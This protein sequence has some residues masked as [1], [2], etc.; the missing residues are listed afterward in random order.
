M[1]SSEEMLYVKGARIWIPNEENVWEGAVLEQDYTKDCKE[2][3]AYKDAGHQQI[4]IKIKSANDLPPLR[5]PTILIGQQ[6]LTAL[7]YLHEPAVLHNL[8][9]RFRERQS[10]Y[11]YCGIILVA[12]NPYAKLPLYGPDI[13]RAYRGHSIG[14]LE[15]HIFALAE[16]AYTKLEREKCDLSIIVSGESGAGKTVSAKYA[17]RY[18]A[19][20]GGSESETQVE[21]KVLESSPI[22]E[23]FGNAKTTRNDNSSRFGKFT[24]L[25]FK[26]NMGVMNLTGATMQTYL[27][28]KSRV[29]YQS[30][31][32]RNYH[33]FYQLCSAREQH[34]E[35]M[36]DHQ[37]KFNFLNKGK[38]PDIERV[39]DVDQFKETVQAM[40][41][42]GFGPT[43]IS[44]IL[45]ILAGIL[46]LGNIQ[47]V[48][49][50]KKDTN[51]IDSDAC[52]I[53]P[54]DLPL[55]V[56]G[57]ML[58]IKADDLRKWLITRQIES[59]HENVLIPNNIAAAESAKDALAKHIYSKLF[60]YIV[61]VINKS[62]NS[63]RKQSCFIGV[64]DIYGFETF[65]TNS[66]EQFCINYANEKL[67][68]QFN[69]HVFKL[70]QEEYLK[71]G[72]VWTMI[73]FYDNQPCIDM[74]ES[75]LGVL[76]LLDEE[77]RMPK[78]SDESW[79]GKL[80]E[81]C[82]K[83][84]HF[85]K[86]RFGTTSF[87]VKHFSDTVQYDVHGF[88]EKNRD[89]VSKELVNVV[90]QSEMTLCK[91]L[92]ELEETDTL[93]EAKTT[94]GGRVVISAS[95]QTL[96][97]D[98][99]K[100][101]TPSKQ[102]KRSVGSQFRDSLSLLIST[103]HSTTPHYVRCIKPNDDK[104][105]FKWEASKI[106]Q[107]LR[108]CGVLE[109]VRISAAG[110]PSRWSYHDFYTRYQLLCHR[111]FLNKSD[112]KSS[113]QN[114]VTKW[115]HDE[116]KYRFGNTQIFFRAGQVAY[117][118][119]VRMNL[120]KKY[121]ITVQSV[122]RKFVYRMRYQRIQRVVLGLQTFARGYIA[123][124][125]ARAIREARAAL[126]ISKYARGY[127]CRRR[128]LKLRF[129][130]C[131]I[132][133]YARGMLARHR[134]KLAMDNHR[135]TQI[136]R[137]C[138][139]YLARQAYKKKLRS[140][141]VCQSAI[142]RFLARRLFRKLKAE[143]KT[144]SHIQNLYK[145]LENKIISLQQKIDELNKENT[146]L[147][148]K[149]TAIPVL[150][151]QLEQKKNI[152]NQLKQLKLLLE[153]KENAL[154]AVDKQLEAE[155]D[156]KMQLL[157][158]KDHEREEWSKQK[159]T[160]RI[161][162]EELRKQV[163]EMIELAKK[164]EKGSLHRSRI[165]SEVDVN[166]VHEAYQRAKKDKDFLE[167]ENYMLKEEISRLQKGNG[168]A[169]EYSN[170]TRSLSNAS[171]Q[172]EEDFGYA[173]AKNTLEP[174][175]MN[176]ALT[177]DSNNQSSMES[178]AKI[179]VTSTPKSEQ[180]SLIL[181]LRGILEEEKK[182]N[183]I[184]VDQM[185]KL[186]NK[187][188]STED[189][190]RVTELEVEN[191]KIRHDYSL[192]RNS[193]SRG[194]EMQ[195]LEAQQSALQ[196]E[197]K[198][199]RDECIQLKAVLQQQS[200]SLKSFG[201]AKPVRTDN[202]FQENSELLEAFQAQKLVNRQLESELSALTEENNAHLAEL[203]RQLD[204]LRNEKA[205]LQTILQSGVEDL[206]EAN[207]EAIRQNERYLRYELEKSY[208][209]YTK[210]QE[211]MNVLTKKYEDAKRTIHTL[212]RR[213]RDHGI[214]SANPNQED[215]KV[216]ASV[217][218]KKT[219]HYKGILK[220][221]KGDLDKISQRLIVGLTPRVAIGLLPG[222]PAYILFMCIRYTDLLNNDDNV[223]K[224]L[225]M[226]VNHMKK[227]HKFPC[228]T[229][230]RVLWL[231][232]SLTLHN[233]LKQYGNIEEYNR[234][235]TPQQNQQLLTNFDLSEY[236]KI[237]Y[238]IIVGLYESLVKQVQGL[239]KQFVV[240]AVLD[241]DEIKNGQNQGN[242]RTI[243]LDGSPE[244]AKVS[245]PRLL[246][247]Q[248]EHYYKQF[249]FFGLHISYTEQIFYQLLYN[250]CAIAMNT[251][252][253]RGD[254]CMWETGMKIRYNVTCLEEWVREKKM[255]SDVTKPLAPL[256]DV[257]QLLQSRKTEQ[258]VDSVYELCNSLTTAQVLKMIKSYN[259][260][261]CEREISSTFIEKLTDK[262]N[263]RNMAR[264]YEFTMDQEF[265]HPVKVVYNY[266][267]VKL[268]DIEIPKQLHLDEILIKI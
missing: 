53:M 159:Q 200:Q 55:H 81:K 214:S 219:H 93:S 256:I 96:P 173:S 261:D 172:N 170:H 48:S 66:F 152:E 178:F 263:N 215:S 115:I 137:F 231:V 6:D 3:N 257:S 103:L 31:G 244:H 80:I 189:S 105:A 65:D 212:T 237:I 51:E 198:R 149:T 45:K 62:L 176:Q 101:V 118:E 202:T 27:L 243:S 160:W 239:I 265:I 77:C 104:V 206:D 89:T 99:R 216:V 46:H 133:Q 43:Q 124:K 179:E 213:L 74:I 129:S 21:R 50:Y 34:P 88:L 233:L 150:K 168:N 123:R 166:E 252:M 194:V 250:I 107:Q 37:D 126:I 76:D 255:S 141:I 38:S 83:F 228:P 268:E 177:F 86:P 144:I 87:L 84:P 95:K 151:N 11:T 114:I 162:N 94:V 224:L 232:N 258:D 223:Q 225:A 203:S 72:I 56:T 158:E 134:F 13:I 120:R 16:E 82:S 248:L 143:A 253:L 209:E 264:N 128:F 238:D 193:I 119:Q 125:K 163:D 136:Q 111:K 217:G 90:A 234:L 121:I 112:L 169:T 28:E 36:L 184:L 4:T 175:R 222:L 113:C 245:A 1:S 91:Q 73:D 156:E 79:A 204:E 85:E 57:D 22:M 122:V 220:Y 49:Q 8:K 236:R 15:P 147:K 142:R 130:V 185:E 54:N 190:L 154:L 182:K 102:H 207:I 266:S 174:K 75:K 247:N 181:K 192:L 116:E 139:G 109:T 249:H 155:R 164:E 92:M 39:S 180:T 132:Q 40:S 5:N 33:I 262:L 52:D 47:F 191:E 63:G 186:M 153:D 240:P 254:I 205:Q 187:N 138:R 67:Q 140:I 235:N 227:V 44:E 108:A 201:G 58:K 23:A 196:E 68:Q 260:D 35:L 197:L 60:Q 226:F 19:A 64:L 59:Y 157:E 267:D 29:V 42:L 242:R 246:V 210:L 7:S 230:N 167:G 106:V 78:G 41:I 218:K 97:V 127:V 146:Q 251:L 165:L 211:D 148:L 30:P 110:F 199:R 26:N 188:K 145:G 25:L 135:A 9:V 10:I 24:K 183:K 117:L 18:F 161:E 241:H 98:K 259:S 229:E 69:Q 20:V 100:R 71:E 17:M 195:E 70:E 131:G 208:M 12:I 32:E 61:A 171:S 221:N 14:E 2:L